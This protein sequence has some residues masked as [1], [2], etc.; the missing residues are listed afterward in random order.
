MAGLNLTGHPRK[1][2]STTSSIAE[3]IQKIRCPIHPHPERSMYSMAKKL[4]I[5]E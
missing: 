2:R 3:D 4:G 1:G 5:N